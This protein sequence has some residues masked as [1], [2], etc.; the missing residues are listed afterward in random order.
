MTPEAIGDRAGGL[1]SLQTGRAVGVRGTE[2][3]RSGGGRST[4]ERACASR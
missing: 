4:E 3:D 2:T 1:R